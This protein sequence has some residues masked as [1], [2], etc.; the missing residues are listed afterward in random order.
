MSN[1]YLLAGSHHIPPE[2]MYVLEGKEETGNKRS[3]EWQRRQNL[4]SHNC[5]VN[6]DDS[7]GAYQ[8]LDCVEM[9]QQV[10]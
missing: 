5:A 8:S 1:N 4:A 10:R 7:N 6:L 2:E 9:S 3:S